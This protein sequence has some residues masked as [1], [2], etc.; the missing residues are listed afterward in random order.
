MTRS[1][2][3]EVTKLT[4]YM[5]AASTHPDLIGTVARALS[6]LIRC[7]HGRNTRSELITVA[8]GWPSVMTHADFII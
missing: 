8:S 5:S 7:T 1:E 3:R 6:S 2:Q 4:N